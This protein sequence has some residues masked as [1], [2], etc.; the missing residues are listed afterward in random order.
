MWGRR[1]P[2]GLLQN[3][4]SQTST[5]QHQT[6]KMYVGSKVAC[7]AATESG[8]SDLH[9]TAP[10]TKN[11]CGVEGGLQGC[12][13]IRFLRPPQHSTKHKKCMWGRR[14][15]AGLLQNQVSQTSTT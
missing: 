3:Q 7:R 6:Q 14:W 1:W 12:Y 8:F 11:V 9:N 15:P 10:N 2:A 13:R 4:V 5:T